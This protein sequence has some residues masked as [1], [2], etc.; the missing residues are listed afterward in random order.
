LVSD[1]KERVKIPSKKKTIYQINSA[2][3]LAIWICLFISGL[4]ISVCAVAYISNSALFN[5]NHI[6]I[7]GNV[8]IKSD[9]VLTLLDIEQGVNIL[10]WDMNKARKRIKDVSIIQG[11]CAC[12]GGRVDLRA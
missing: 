1:F 10:S 7:K 3:R 8:H 4:L 6:D 9:E 5:V 11:L 2:L 12:I